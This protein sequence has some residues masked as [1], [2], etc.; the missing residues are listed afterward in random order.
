MYFATIKC[1]KKQEVSRVTTHC[2]NNTSF[3]NWSFINL[4]WDLYFSI[5]GPE[6][7]SC[8]LFF[9]PPPYRSLSIISCRT[10]LVVLNSPSFCLSKTVLISPTLL[11]VTFDEH[12]IFGWQIFLFVCLV[13]LA[14]WIH[15]YTAFWPPKFLMRNLLVVLLRIP[16]MWW[17]WI[18]LS[19]FNILFV[20]FYLGSS[21][22][23][24]LGV[25]ETLWVFLA[26]YLLSFLDFILSFIKF[27]KFSV[28]ISSNILSAPFFFFWAFHSA[29]VGR[30]VDVPH[31]SYD[32]F[33]FFQVF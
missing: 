22:I 8:V 18:S 28:I 31:A 16:C 1:L 5:M 33:T 24:H 14:L 11:R 4:Y 26:W 23:M 3:Y 29:N 15:W 21:I 25:W 6:L 19:I 32:L 27:R 13:L 2:F 9:T 12:R 7:L 17:F 10:S 20:S 30:L